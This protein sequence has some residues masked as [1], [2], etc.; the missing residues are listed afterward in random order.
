MIE[1]ERL[2]RVPFVDPYHGFDISPDGGK[3]AF[4]WNKT[5][6]WELYDL[7]LPDSAAKIPASAPPDPTMLTK[8]EQGAKFAPRYSPDGSRLA[9]VVDFDGGEDFHL[10]I[11]DAL[12]GTHT[13]LTPGIKYALQ[14]NFCWSPDGSEIA[15]VSDQSGTFNAYCMPAAGGAARCILSIGRPV[16]DI[17]WSPDGA[18]LAVTFESTGQDYGVYLVPHGGEGR[19]VL[20][21]ENEPLNA[22]NP[23]W[24]PDGKTL[25]FHSDRL[26][27]FHQ[28]GMFDLVNRKID[29]L[30]AETA[31]Y[32][33]PVFSRDGAMLAY[34]RAQGAAD[35]I[36]V[37]SLQ[38]AEELPSEKMR[39]SVERGVHYRPHFSPDGE[40]I[41]FPFNNPRF[42]PDLW[43]LSLASGELTQLTYS[44]PDELVNQLNDMPE[45]ITY[46]GMD[47]TLIP[48]LLFKPQ[49]AQPTPAVIVIHGGPNWHYQL[50][51]NPFMTHLASRGWTVLAPN[52]RGSTGY[53]RNWQ[54]ANHFDLGG[55][56]ADDVAAGAHFLVGEKLGDPAKIAVTGRSHGGYLTLTSLTRYPELWTVGSGVVP[57][58]NW[59]TC[60]AR[61]RGDLQHWDIEVMGDPVQNHDLWHDRSPYF[62]LDQMRAPVQLICGAHDPRCPAEDSMDARDQL[63]A[64]GK[65]VEFHLYDDEGHAFL[66]TANVIRSEVQRVVFLARHLDS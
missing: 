42:P 54:Y 46:P 45:E 20:S 66:K 40:Y 47:G 13:D 56:D 4:A 55:V 23:C 22:H 10:F 35:E 11:S 58:T 33:T 18:W 29:W 31:N 32:R 17:H 12:S 28:I 19:F 53:G 43:K 65:Q 5:G 24:S 37:S 34:V 16:W 57:F 62:F 38:T 3:L 52:Y 30:T 41:F 64:L 25:V 48:A 9:Y 27:G 44:L 60:H 7:P 36:V 39:Y 51:W 49:T 8:G 15:F 50:E 59:F 21:Y 2:L 1:L 26:N 14:P 63:I 61:S 6:Q